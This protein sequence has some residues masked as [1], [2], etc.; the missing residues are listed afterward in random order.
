MNIIILGASKVGYHLARQLIQEDKHVTIIERDPHRAKQVSNQL[1][2]IVIND[3][4][5]NLEVLNQAG[6]EKANYFISVTESDELNMIACGLAASNSKNIST[7]ARI[8]N[9][10]Y[11]HSKMSS[12][13]V[14]GINHIINPEIEAAK[15]IAKSVEHGAMSNIMLFDNTDLQMRNLTITAGSSLISQ[16]LHQV[17]EAINATFLVPILLRD[18]NHLIPNGNTVFLENDLLYIIAT[19]EDFNTIFDFFDKPKKTFNKV[20]II[21]CGKLGCYIAD[22]LDSYQ[23]EDTGLIGRIFKRFI[24]NNRKKLHLIDTDYKQCKF[25]NKRYPQAMITH[26]DIT[27][28]EIWEEE[29]LKDYDLVISSTGNQELNLITSIYAKKVGVSRAISLVQT[30]AYKRIAESLGIDVSVSINEVL[31]NKILKLI[32]QGNIKS[33]YNISGSPF[34]I[35]EFEIHQ[36]SS[37]CKK[38]IKYIKLPKE[39]L[40]ILISREEINII[41]HGSLAIEPNDHVVLI[42]RNDATKRLESIFKVK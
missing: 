6:L 29:L 7:I 31:V 25:L 41:P 14:L 1:D 10:D 37:L 2:C 40:I 20:A 18:D 3:T 5:N 11:S 13:T 16:T 9:I 23:E 22:Y 12:K 15:E 24:K 39:T 17:N 28:E 34:E 21:G 38:L 8:R 19:D 30:K 27:D 32:R 26:A 4:G 42:T 35:I 33:I 36:T